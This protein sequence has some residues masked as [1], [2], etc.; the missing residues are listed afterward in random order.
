MIPNINVYMDTEFDGDFNFLGNS[1]VTGYVM[2]PTAYLNQSGTP[3]LLDIKYNSYNYMP[4]NTGFIGSVIFK[5]IDAQN[6]A[7]FVYVNPEPKSD[8]VSEPEKPVK[9]TVLYYQ[10]Y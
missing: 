1:A 8:S 9:F 10:C 4:I 3:P 5:E 2:S 7:G 6:A